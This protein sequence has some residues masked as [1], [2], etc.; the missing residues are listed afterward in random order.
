MSDRTVA[1]ALAE[2]LGGVAFRLSEAVLRA[3]DGT[4]AAALDR[5]DV[6]RIHADRYRVGLVVLAGPAGVL[7]TAID[8][9]IAG[10]DLRAAVGFAETVIVHGVADPLGV[11]G[12]CSESRKHESG[13]SRDQ[14]LHRF[15]PLMNNQ[16][17]TCPSPG[18]ARE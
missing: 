8:G 14:S 13:R 16:K 11:C 4:R 12:A 3:G 10:A 9:R 5:H 18:W 6:P 17:K 7:L 15:S 1:G 2:F